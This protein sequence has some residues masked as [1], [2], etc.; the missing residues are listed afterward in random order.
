MI[1]YKKEFMTSMESIKTFQEDQQ[2]VNDGLKKLCE[3]SSLGVSLGDHLMDRLVKVTSLLVATEEVL[4]E[5]VEDWVNWHIWE[6]EWGARKLV[7]TFVD[8]T[9]EHVVLNLE[10]LWMAIF[11][12]GECILDLLEFAPVSQ[13][14]QTKLEKYL[15]DHKYYLDIAHS[16]DISWNEV[17]TSFMEYVYTPI[18][19]AMKRTRLHKHLNKE[20]IELFIIYMESSER[21]TKQF[22]K[23]WLHP[24][25]MSVCNFILYQKYYESYWSVKR[26]PLDKLKYKWYAGKISYVLESKD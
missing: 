8:S 23:G 2:A 24:D 3:N 7:Y 10:D 4:P 19:Q 11:S 25:P 5:Y 20:D 26:K 13:E 17:Y 15:T 21:L 14:V 22:A 1:D 18:Q 9:K 12:K 6:N 16:K